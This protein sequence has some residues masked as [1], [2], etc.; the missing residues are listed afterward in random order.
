MTD[1]S[2]IICYWH[3]YHGYNMQRT[4]RENCFP[5]NILTAC[6]CLSLLI[7]TYEGKTSFKTSILKILYC[8]LS[9]SSLVVVNNDRNANEKTK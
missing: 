7:T 3:S 9:T 8:N 1:T 6:L 4:L 2:G 5:C